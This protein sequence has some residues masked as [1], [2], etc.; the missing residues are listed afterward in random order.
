[1]N[2]VTSMDLSTANAM[3]PPQRVTAAPPVAKRIATLVVASRSV[4]ETDAAA[5][6]GESE[7]AIAAA[8]STTPRRMSPRRSFSLVPA[9]SRL[10][11]VPAG[12][13]EPVLLDQRL[14]P[15]K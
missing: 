6:R 9:A 2:L 13:S 10:R 15:S 11:T 8:G 14:R 12:H 7:A 4:V 5:D 3:S 1:M